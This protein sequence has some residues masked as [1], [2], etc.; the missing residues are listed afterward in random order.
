MLVDLNSSIE[1]N[2]SEV[3]YLDTDNALILFNISSE[4]VW[5]TEAN[6]TVNQTGNQTVN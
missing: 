5:I 4:I 2:L 1:I 6:Q 3:D